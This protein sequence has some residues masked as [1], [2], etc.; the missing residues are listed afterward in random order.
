MRT[1]KIVINNQEYIVEIYTEQRNNVTVSIRKNKIIIKVP[2]SINRE[3][4][5]RNVL[6]MKQWAV[7]KITRDP[8]RFKKREEKQYRSGDILQIN[9]EQFLL[10][11]GYCDNS[12]SSGRIRENKIVLDISSRLNEEIKRKHIIAL[13]SRIIAKRRLP[14]LERKIHELNQQH[15]QKEINRIFFKNMNSRWGSCSENANINISTRLLFAPEIVLEYV[16]I[17]ELAH[18]IEQNHSSNF[19]NLVQQAM[20]DYKDQEQWLK[21]NGDSCQF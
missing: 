5:F 8:E 12:S 10:E 11:I 7:K 19:W 18:L 1:E 21:K 9:N 6:E 13:L 17:H 4:Q 20:P 2:I 3:E 14:I 16:C 15:F